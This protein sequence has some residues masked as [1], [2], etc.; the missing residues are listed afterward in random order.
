MLSHC[1]RERERER[2]REGERGRER[3]RERER[4]RVCVCVCV[5][6]RGCEARRSDA[7][8]ENTMSLENHLMTLDRLQVDLKRIQEGFKK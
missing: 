7:H 3:E 8:Q 5:C 6:E 4:E 2:G 1:H